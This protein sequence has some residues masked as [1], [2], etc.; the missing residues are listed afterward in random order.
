MR[1]A[2]TPLLA[3]LV[4]PAGAEEP[5]GTAPAWD[6]PE[7][8]AEAQRA[9]GAARELIT[10]SERRDGRPAARA[11][12]DRS[13]LVRLV[14]IERLGVLGLDSKT[15]AALRARAGPGEP[16]P[17]DWPAAEQARTFAEALPVAGLLGGELS[18]SEGLKAL[19]VVALDRIEEGPED[20]A[21]KRAMAEELLAFQAVVTAQ[22]RAWLAEALAG[23]AEEP[24]ILRDLAAPDLAAAR[25][26]DGARLL[27]WWAEN[28][29][30][31]S[32]SGKARRFV[33]D[34]EARSAG[35]PSAT[36]R[37][38]KPWPPE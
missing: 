29:P 8:R 22:D 34:R 28:A 17:A 10:A 35:V 36:H 23:L 18:P 1:R 32:W 15:I 2:L 31:L 5:R 14:A 38:G 19:L 33:L 13:W 16:P 11:L 21:K 30:Y 37:R 9:I 27:R 24:A 7:A 25:G 6:R 4:L 20:G 3:L 12:R 26:E